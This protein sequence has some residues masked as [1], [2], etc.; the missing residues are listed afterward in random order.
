MIK[1]KTINKEKGVIIIR[2]KMKKV[3]SDNEVAELKEVVIEV[4]IEVEE[5]EEEVT[6]KEIIKSKNLMK[7]DQSTKIKKSTRKNLIDKSL[8]IQTT[9]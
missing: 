3:I 2:E 8:M 6:I 9:Q 7:I 4:V 1:T 5:V